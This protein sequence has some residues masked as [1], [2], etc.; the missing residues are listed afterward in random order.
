MSQLVG[1]N[2]LPLS[3]PPDPDALRK[4]G[5]GDSPLPHPLTYAALFNV[6][7][8]NYYQRLFDEARRKGFDFAGTMRNDSFLTGLMWERTL[9]VTS[10]PWHL[11]IDDENDPRQCAVRD[12]LTKQLKRTPQFRGMMK[13]LQ[14]ER[15]WYGRTAVETNYAWAD[16]PFTLPVLPAAPTQ[17]PGQPPQE[18]DPDGGLPIEKPGAPAQPPVTPAVAPVNQRSLYVKEWF[19]INGDKIGHMWNG[20][21]TILVNASQTD[22]IADAEFVYNDLNKALVVSGSWKDHFLFH[23]AWPEDSDFFDGFEAAE[24]RFGVGVRSKIALWQWIRMEWVAKI[25]DFMDRSIPKK[26]W[27]WE[28]GNAASEE[29]VRLAAKTDS[30]KTDIILPRSALNKNQG[31]EYLQASMENVTQLMELVKHIEQEY[32]IPLINGQKMSRDHTGSGGLGGSGAADM[33]GDTKGNITED[34]A[35]SLAECLTGGPDVHGLVYF[36]QRHTFPETLPSRPG[37]FP[38][39]FVLGY[40]DPKGKERLETIKLAGEM[41]PVKAADV[42]KAAGLT[43]P[44]A[45]DELAEKPAPKANPF[46]SGG[47]GEEKKGKDAAGEEKPPEKPAAPPQ[48]FQA[49]DLRDRIEAATEEF[50]AGLLNLATQREAAEADRREHFD[51]L[52]AEV[53]AAVAPKEP[54][55]EPDPTAPPEVRMVYS[56]DGL[57]TETRQEYRGAELVTRFERDETGAVVRK[58][59]SIELDRHSEDAQGNQHKPPGQGGG[60]FTNKGKSDKPPPADT[61]GTAKQPPPAAARTETYYTGPASRTPVKVP[62]LSRSDAKDAPAAAKLAAAM[63]GIVEQIEKQNRGSPALLKDVYAALKA[64]EPTLDLPTFHRQLLAWQRDEKVGL[65]KTNE[66]KLL[67]PDDL[68]HSLV[69]EPKNALAPVALF[70]WLQWTAKPEG[71]K[72]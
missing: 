51:A 26:L 61:G 21:P 6:A 45:T 38:V 39:R 16:M 9:A 57:L 53:R 65:L 17:A 37:G 56:A 22:K 67:E 15:T 8:R 55:P 42:Y 63:P 54:P 28:L 10:L 24:A 31:V 20:T 59:P 27:Y 64:V 36:L 4:A 70:S 60:Q 29:A 71:A 32:L 35:N 50:R 19:P 23:Y 30:D 25:S 49:D 44:T 18:R 13:S 58:V 33:A 52:S 11:E 62:I 46:D 72:P 69:I 40:M 7:W 48:Q 2:G 3:V 43:K 34:D 14:Y 66:A 1:P 12:H 68:T 47:E 5:F 41:V